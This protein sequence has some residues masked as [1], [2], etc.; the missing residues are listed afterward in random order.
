M[1][2]RLPPLAWCGPW[3]PLVLTHVCNAPADPPLGLLLRTD[4]ASRSSD[5]LRVMRCLF[6]VTVQLFH[7][8]HKPPRSPVPI[9]PLSQALSGIT[10]LDLSRNLAG[11]Y[12]TML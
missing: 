5:T 2:S 12:C 11:P 4:S 6:A 10:V 1:P 7:S 3:N 8:H 9:S